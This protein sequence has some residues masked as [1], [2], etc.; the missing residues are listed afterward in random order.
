MTACQP[1]EKMRQQWA[2]AQ[3]SAE[4]QLVMAGERWGQRHAAA[5]WEG[6][7]ELYTDDAV[8]MPNG[9]PKI[10]GADNIVAFLRRVP[11]AGGTTRIIFQNEEVHVD[12]LGGYPDR[13]IVTAK[14]LMTITMPETAPVQIAGRALLVY[15]WEGGAWKLW[16]DMDN[17]A[18]DVRIE[19]L[20]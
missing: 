14:Y 12:M 9:Q 16:R 15:R 18:P 3:Q 19:D 13:G 20:Q 6:L 8:L 1:T 10:E 2:A 4:A 11:D 17:S 7:R 5:D